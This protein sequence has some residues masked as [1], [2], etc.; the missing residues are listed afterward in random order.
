M[1]LFFALAIMVAGAAVSFQA[2]ANA[3]LSARTGLGPALIVNTLIVLV[4][5]IGFSPPVS[6]ISEVL[7]PL[8]TNW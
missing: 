2:A 4:C 7:A 1:N 3:G 8:T 6:S 5:A